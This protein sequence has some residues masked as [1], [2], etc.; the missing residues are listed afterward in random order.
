[1]SH[2]IRIQIGGTRRTLYFHTPFI[3]S[4]APKTE[5]LQSMP[6][7]SCILVAALMICPLALGQS[8]ETAQLRLLEDAHSY[9]ASNHRDNTYAIH[10]YENV[11]ELLSLEDRIRLEIMFRIANMYLFDMGPQLQHIPDVTRALEKYNEII[12]RFPEEE[13]MVLQA[14]GYSA[15]CYLRLG[16]KPAAEKEYLHVRRFA[17]G[18]SNDRASDYAPFLEAWK[19][20]ASQN[21]IA[22]YKDDGLLGTVDLKRIADENPQDPEL[23][24]AVQNAITE[25]RSKNSQYNW[26]EDPALLARPG[27]E[28]PSGRNSSTLQEDLEAVWPLD[29]S[30][31]EIQV[32]LESEATSSSKPSRDERHP[33]YP[34]LC[35]GATALGIVALV[36]AGRFHRWI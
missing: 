30:R 21:L 13:S 4:G 1:M 31:S 22:M 34:W 27:N 14:H 18:I 6:M 25:I 10:L 15:D 16:N 2:P 8:P 17:L 12:E 29:P 28:A 5:A 33:T 32:D 23:V 20:A 24:E 11:L 3:V 36:V 26:L 19:K 9:Y 7:S 35:L